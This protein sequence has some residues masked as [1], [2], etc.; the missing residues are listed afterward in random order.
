MTTLV[1]TFQPVST[2]SLGHITCIA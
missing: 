2:V 1:S